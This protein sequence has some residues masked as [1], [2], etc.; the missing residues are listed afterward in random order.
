LTP[1]KGEFI[2]VE[3]KK[4]GNIW[5]KGF[6]GS[7]KS[8]LLIHSLNEYITKIEPNSKVVVLVF[9]HALKDMFEIGISELKPYYKNK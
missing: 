1:T 3:S 5:V 7:G 9:T 4:T 8:V 6:A 2:N